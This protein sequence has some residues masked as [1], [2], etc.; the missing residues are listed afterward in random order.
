MGL[1][2]KRKIILGQDKD[3][4]G[5]MGQPVVQNVT[6]KFKKRYEDSTSNVGGFELNGGER[7]TRGAKTVWEE[8]TAW[9]KERNMDAEYNNNDDLN[10]IKTRLTNK[11]KNKNKNK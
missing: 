9:A 10:T 3:I 2:S 1:F 4:K 7:M 5:P 6:E 11:V 8:F